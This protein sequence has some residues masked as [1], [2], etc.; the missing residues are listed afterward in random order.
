MPRLQRWIVARKIVP[1]FSTETAKK[2]TDLGANLGDGDFNLHQI[3]N[4][5]FRNREKVIELLIADGFSVT[6][7]EDEAAAKAKTKE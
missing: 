7:A 5:N 6:D 2:L 4:V 1:V 3:V